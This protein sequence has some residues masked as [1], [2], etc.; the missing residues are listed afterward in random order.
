MPTGTGIWPA[1]WALGANY[2]AVGWP[3]CGEIDISE[4]IGSAGSVTHASVHGPASGA[5]PYSFTGSYRA[6]RALSSGF[7]VYSVH[8]TP[9][10]LTFTVD[11]SSVYTVT[12]AVVL[13]SGGSWVFDHPF[14]LLLNV[15]VGGT[16]PG[17][18]SA[19]TAWP[20]QMVVDYVRVYQDR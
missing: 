20:Q 4:V 15:A 9:T 5:A 11:S 17:P 1:L 13:A 7:H 2:G 16:W 14:F 6:P 10:A 3:R 12:K 19:S 18:P 8:W